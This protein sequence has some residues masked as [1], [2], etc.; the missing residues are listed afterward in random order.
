MDASQVSQALDGGKS[1]AERLKNLPQRRC[2]LKSAS[3]R[4]T[5]LE[6][7]TVREAKVDYT[8]LL[9]R[10]RYTRGRVRAHIDRDIAKRQE[11]IGHSAD[12]VLHEWE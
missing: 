12:E 3:D 1:L 9:N 11:G 10:S 7:P 4:W 8:D 5:E 2:I 6:V